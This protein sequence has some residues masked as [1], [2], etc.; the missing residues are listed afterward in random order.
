MKLPFTKKGQGAGKS[1]G[2]EQLSGNSKNRASFSSSDLKV[3][4]KDVI[5][6]NRNE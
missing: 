6:V 5:P 1:L 2:I 3:Q 4:Q